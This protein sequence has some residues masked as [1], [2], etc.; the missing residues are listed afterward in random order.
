MSVVLNFQK[1]DI[2]AIEKALAGFERIPATSEYE[3]SR[4]RSEGNVVVVYSSGKTVIQGKS[5]EST[6]AV[7]LERMGLSEELVLGFDEAGRGEKTGPMVV[8]GVFGDTNALREVRDSKKT[9]NIG[10]KFGVVSRNMLASAAFVLNAEFVDRLRKKGLNLNEIEARIIDG[11][12]GVF[13]ELSENPKIIVDGNPLRTKNKSLVY[14]A[15]ADDL[16]PVVGAASV[17]AKFLRETSKDD[18]KRETW[19]EK[20]A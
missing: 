14:L 8:A 20:S 10:E 11:L 15:K 12:A 18:K 13:S 4:F 7:L 5:P 17:T 6:K 16:E 2:P 1:K 9:G 19:K 3:Q